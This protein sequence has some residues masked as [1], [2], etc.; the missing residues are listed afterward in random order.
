MEPASE[1]TDTK[2][3]RLQIDSDRARNLVRKLA[4]EV[5]SSPDV[6]CQAALA[7]ND[8]VKMLKSLKINADHAHKDLLRMAKF[9][10]RGRQPNNIH[11]QLQKLLGEPDA[12]TPTAFRVDADYLRTKI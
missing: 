9:G 2:T 4:W 6:Q 8:Q 5:F 10:S 11:G 3:N 7:Y 1:S 12:P